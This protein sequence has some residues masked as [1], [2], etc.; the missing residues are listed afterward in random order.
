M[1]ED[2]KIWKKKSLKLCDIE[3]G[4]SVGKSLEWK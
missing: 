1:N 3:N 2:E 4:A